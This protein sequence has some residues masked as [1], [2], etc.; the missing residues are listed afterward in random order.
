MHAEKG[1]IM[2]MPL[3]ASFSQGGR[4]GGEKEKELALSL[5]KNIALL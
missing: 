1:M 2:R 4:E 3:S 5:K